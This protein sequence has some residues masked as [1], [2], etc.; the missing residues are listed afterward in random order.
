MKIS[1]LSKINI[2]DIDVAKLQDQLLQRK[3]IL[4]QVVLGVISVVIAVSVFNQSQL[5]IK[6]Y[7]SQIASLQSKTGAIDEYNRTQADV[8]GFL[9]KVPDSVPEDKI[10][11]LVTDLAGKNGVKILTFS[12]AN[13]KK[14]NTLVTTS[15]NF[16]LVAD[17]FVSMVRFI[18]DIEKGKDFLQI[19]SCDMVPQMNSKESGKKSSNIPI[20]FQIDVA[21]IMVEE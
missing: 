16:S 19:W 1:D 8:K 9:S 6:K 15:L 5:E 2:K 10:I 3:D 7:K 11:N 12:Q 4:I 20:N 13:V 14:E 17:S 21:S 18:A